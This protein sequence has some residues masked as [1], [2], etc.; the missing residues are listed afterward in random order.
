[1]PVEGTPIMDRQLYRRTPAEVQLQERGNAWNT[2]NLA[3]HVQ[4]DRDAARARSSSRSSRGRSGSR[5]NR[6]NRSDSVGSRR[7]QRGCAGS[8][9]Y[10]TIG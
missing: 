6:D 7:S 9:N 2:G 8:V 4:Q 3:S 10:C 5:N 1:M